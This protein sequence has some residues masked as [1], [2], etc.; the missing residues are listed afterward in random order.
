MVARIRRTVRERLAAEPALCAR[1]ERGE[2]G[3]QEAAELL[4]PPTESD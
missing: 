3:T 4:M 1:V 2:V